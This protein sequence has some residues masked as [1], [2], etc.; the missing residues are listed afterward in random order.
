V[1][2]VKR[3]GALPEPLERPESEQR[4]GSGAWDRHAAG[5]D[6][7]GTDHGYRTNDPG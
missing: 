7:P 3:I 5:D 1:Q 4:L 2:Q 6:Q